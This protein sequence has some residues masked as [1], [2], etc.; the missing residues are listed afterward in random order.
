MVYY[1]YPGSGIGLALSRL[2]NIA[3]DGTPDP[4]E[5][6]AAYTYLGAGTIVN[7]AHPGVTNGLDLTYG[8]GGTYGGFD[9]FGRVVDQKWQNTAATP[10]DRFTY[11]YDSVSNRLYE[12]NEVATT[13]SE[14]YHAS[15]A[16]SGYY[17][18]L[19][20]L[21]EFRRGTLGDSGGTNNAI[22]GDAGG[23]QTWGLDPPG[24]WTSFNKDATDGITWDLEQ[25]RT[26]NTD[27]NEI[28]GISG[29]SWVVPAHDANGNMTLMPRPGDE[30]DA[31]DA[32]VAVY[33]AWNRPVKVYD[34]DDGGGDADDP[35]ELVATYSY[36]G[37]NR[38]IRKVVEGAPDVTYDFY[39][40]SSWQLLETRKDESS[41]ANPIKQYVWDIRY[42]DAL[43]VRFRDTD[44]DE[45][46]ND[47][48]YYCN[49]ANMNVTALIEDDGT[50]AE[51]YLY[52]PYGEVTVLN[53]DWS[54]DGGEDDYDNEILFAGY[55]Y[56]PETGLYHVRNRPYHPTLGRWIVRDFEYVDGMSLYQYC[57]SDPE[58]YVDPTGLQGSDPD[59]PDEPGNPELKEWPPN[60]KHKHGK[61]GL[62]HREGSP[63][64]TDG[65]K[66]SPN[67]GATD[68]V[69]KPGINSIDGEKHP[70]NLPDDVTNGK[71]K[72]DRRKQLDKMGR[73]L[74][75]EEV[76]DEGNNYYD[77]DSV[78]AL[79]IATGAAA[80]EG[81]NKV[82]VPA[83]SRLP[84]ALG[85]GG[86]AS[87]GGGAA[88]G[89]AVTGGLTV[90]G[91][92]VSGAA[93]I[94][95]VTSVANADAE[96]PPI[97]IPPTDCVTCRCSV[98]IDRMVDSIFESGGPRP[99]WPRVQKFRK[100]PGWDTKTK[101]MRK[102]EADKAC[103]KAKEQ[104]WPGMRNLDFRWWGVYFTRHWVSCD[105]TRRAQRKSRP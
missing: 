99:V 27:V 78:N 85:S 2:D 24:N 84:G 93:V 40:N 80:L 14:L 47:T 41:N 77:Q 73:D 52:D 26:H 92:F 6:Y 30:A 15:G 23:R 57:L 87:A 46:V 21:K 103:A 68:N 71:T 102:G 16:T 8:T 39:Y 44:Q 49:D 48:L 28:T 101:R 60:P 31:T 66:N 42:I 95:L 12:K 1:N 37:Q 91:Q 79:R 36:D 7:V 104:V 34:D 20:R 98:V 45:T 11:G 17:D 59:F 3:S 53:P 63:G 43:I 38:W 83:L 81:I 35:G 65:V 33:D 25:T 64:R 70:R 90:A 29:G 9:R 62:P 97:R 61:P 75:G 10:F 58:V 13:L 4:D 56:D 51:R 100:C 19:D 74:S 22:S 89:A 50:V 76:E 96:L 54:A 69:G 94:L 55:R 86:T 5:K 72:T 82:L 88:G 18:G 105:T 32:L 67:G